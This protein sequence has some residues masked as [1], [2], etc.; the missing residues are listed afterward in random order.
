MEARDTEASAGNLASRHHSCPPWCVA[1]H[2]SHAPWAWPQTH[3][4]A[5]TRISPARSDFSQ[6]IA[7]EVLYNDDDLWQIGQVVFLNASSSRISPGSWPH[8]FLTP[9]N[10]KAF[11]DVITILASAT[12]Q[13]HRDLADGMR[14]CAALINDEGESGGPA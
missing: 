5:T 3:H 11:A 13:Q 8:L 12:P 2:D 7:A 10:A 9:K 1:D 14:R 4:S 6:S